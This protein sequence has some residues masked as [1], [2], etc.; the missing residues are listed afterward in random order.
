MSADLK[1]EFERTGTPRRSCIVVC[2]SCGARHESSDEDERSGMSWNERAADAMSIRLEMAA[3]GWYSE[4]RLSDI[5]WGKGK[6]G[7][8]IWFERYDWHGQHTLKIN[9]KKACYHSHTPDLTKIDEVTQR[10]AERA[11]RAWRDFS[12]VPPE[13]GL[14]GELSPG[15]RLTTKQEGQS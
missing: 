6:P 15:R 3:D 8:S 2:H 9:G 1:A 12:D 13:Q 7:Y 5:G 14:Q 11:R 10:A 4:D